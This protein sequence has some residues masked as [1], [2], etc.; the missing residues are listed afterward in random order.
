MNS[1]VA[2]GERFELSV[3]IMPTTVFET[4]PF[5]HSGTPPSF[6]SRFSI[7]LKRMYRLLCGTPR[8]IE[9]FEKI[10]EEFTNSLPDKQNLPEER[11]SLDS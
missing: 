3:G 1:H 4:A 5:S 6:N 8:V 9:Q 10:A 2:E 11:I 7:S